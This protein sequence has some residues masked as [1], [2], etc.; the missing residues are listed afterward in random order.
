[1]E[2]RYASDGSEERIV[3]RKASGV[4]RGYG[5]LDVYQNSY[6][7]MLTIF[8]HILPLLPKEERFDLADQLRRSCKAIPRLI[9]EGH[10]KRHQARG[11]Q[12]YIDDAH[13]ESNETIVSLTQVKDLYASTANS[14]ALI[15]LIDLYDKI[16]RQLFNLSHSW[17]SYSKY[18]R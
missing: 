2:E 8:K 9:A 7:A 4:I 16:S 1:M 3:R 14:A 10:S 18:R 12:K 13:A 11:F 5:D 15:K 6:K 17:R